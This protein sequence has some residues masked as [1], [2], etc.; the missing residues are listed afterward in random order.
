[1]RCQLVQA[2]TSRCRQ[3]RRRGCARNACSRPAW[4]LI[5]NAESS[6]WECDNEKAHS[7]RTDTPLHINPV[8]VSNAHE[9][10]KALCRV[11]KAVDPRVTVHVLEAP[12]SCAGAPAAEEGGQ[13]PLPQHSRLQPAVPN[14]WWRDRRKRREDFPCALHIPSRRHRRDHI[15]VRSRYNDKPRVDH[16]LADIPDDINVDV[17]NQLFPHGG[18]VNANMVEQEIIVE[19]DKECG[20]YLLAAPDARLKE[21]AR[22]ATQCDPVL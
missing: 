18:V 4:A 13:G 5:G 7:R 12:D 22:R 8:Q 21:N 17:L 11:R 19:S 10:G 16:T 15:N 1:M 2:A 14:E 3:T 6:L 9:T 20:R